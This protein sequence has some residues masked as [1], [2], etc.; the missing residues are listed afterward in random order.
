MASSSWSAMTALAE[1]TDMSPEEFQRMFFADCSPLTEQEASSNRSPVTAVTYSDMPPE[2]YARLFFAD[3]STLT[4]QQRDTRKNAPIHF[5][6]DHLVDQLHRAR[7]SGSN[8]TVVMNLFIR[9]NPKPKACSK[10]CS[11]PATKR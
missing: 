9:P 1:D 5:D 10:K 4:Q 2:E 8:H 7:S 6:L 11:G 3:S